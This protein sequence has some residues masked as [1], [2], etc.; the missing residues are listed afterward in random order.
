MTIITSEL[1]KAHLSDRKPSV[2]TPKIS[3]T[4]S[5]SRATIE[6]IKKNYQRIGSMLVVTSEKHAIK[7]RKLKHSH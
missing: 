4:I 5:E 6:V 1:E 7:L 3:I 2:K